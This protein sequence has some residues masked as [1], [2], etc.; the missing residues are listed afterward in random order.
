MQFYRLIYCYFYSYFCN[1]VC[2]IGAHPEDFIGCY[3]AHYDALHLPHFPWDLLLL[4]VCWKLA[5]YSCTAMLQE[6]ASLMAIEGT[7]EGAV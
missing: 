6:I 5:S 2:G 3:D 4:K 7:I 1:K